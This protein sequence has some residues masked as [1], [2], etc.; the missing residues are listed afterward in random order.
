VK[1][2][3]ITCLVLDFG[4]NSEDADREA[5]ERDLRESTLAGTR[6]ACADR[7]MTLEKA[8]A[9]GL[10]HLGVSVQWVDE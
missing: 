5:L 4:D 2:V 10:E 3:V 8:K 7:G 9:M 6:R 1:A